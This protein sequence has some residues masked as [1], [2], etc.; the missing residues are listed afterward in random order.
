MIERPAIAVVVL[1]GV[2]CGGTPAPDTT[3]AP[4]WSAP[5]RG[6]VLEIA[7]G[8][9]ADA[10]QYAALHL[11]SGYFRLR[12]AGTSWGTSIILPP[13]LWKDGRYH[14]GTRVQAAVA[15]SGSA[16]VVS[17]EGTIAD[18]PFAGQVIVQPPSPDATTAI[19]S[20]RLGV[21]P[22]LDARPGEAFKIAALSS[23]WVGPRAWDTSLARVGLATYAIPEEGW[24]VAP[25][26]HATTF[27]LLGGDS[28]W[29]TDAPTIEIALAQPLLVTGWVTRSQDPNDDNVSLWAGS[30]TAVEQWSYT[31]VAKP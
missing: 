30:D 19:V 25:G 10:P 2:G 28:D 16:L 20:G 18:V 12:S 21:L 5:T 27:G 4:S 3:S 24:I 17:Y 13:A 6:E 31:V 1:L 29:K 15:P 9:A 14:Q 8:T 11:D 22:T 7:Y 26:V 23:M